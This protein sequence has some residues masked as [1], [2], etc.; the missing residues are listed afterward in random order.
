MYSSFLTVDIPILH[1]FAFAFT[2]VPD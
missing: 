1:I 2:L